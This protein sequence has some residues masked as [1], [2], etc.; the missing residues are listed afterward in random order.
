M[1]VTKNRKNI[2]FLS[3]QYT[4]G[5]TNV[6]HEGSKDRFIMLGRR[7]AHPALRNG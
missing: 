1:I 7:T 5:D 6:Q 4:Q 3:D 2:H